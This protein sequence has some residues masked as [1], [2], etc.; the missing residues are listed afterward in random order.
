VLL[1]R[2]HGDDEPRVALNARGHFLGLHQLETERRAD[3]V[4][5]GQLTHVVQKLGSVVQAVCRDGSDG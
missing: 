1:A 5:G 3:A 4:D 2:P